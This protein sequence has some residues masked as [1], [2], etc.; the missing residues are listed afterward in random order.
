M[1]L[2]E[3]G[4]SLQTAVPATEPEAAAPAAAE[5]VYRAAADAF[6]GQAA[7]HM[8]SGP[9][10]RS[11]AQKGDL[12]VPAKAAETL[13]TQGSAAIQ[14]ETTQPE[15]ISTQPTLPTAVPMGETEGAAAPAELFYREGEPAA[16]FAADVQTAI[17]TQL[18]QRPAEGRHGKAEASRPGKPA[19]SANSPNNA[20][21][22]GATQ[23]QGAAKPTA[24]QSQDAMP[25]QNDTEAAEETALPAAIPATE[26]E[27]DTA[28]PA[29]LIYRTQTGASAL[30]GA[31]QA[32]DAI[33][34]SRPAARIARDIRVSAPPQSAAAWNG[35]HAASAPEPAGEIQT[36]ATA[37][38]APEET[39]MGIPPEMFY[40]APQFGTAPEAPSVDAV[41]PT[42]R[43]Q[44]KAGQSDM[45][46][47]AKD[48][49]EKAGVKDTVEYTSAFTGQAAASSGQKQ[50]TWTAPNVPDPRQ[51]SS[52]SGPM[53]LTFKEQTV[54][55]EEPF[56]KQM[57]SDAEIQRTADRVYHILEERLRR[58]LRRS[59]R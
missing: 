54:Q 16:E 20:A 2:E 42:E 46:A 50:I 36:S 53:D 29:E 37:V 49:L 44:R 56:Y 32:V 43:A 17:K 45:P 9:V 21:T 10:S 13:D 27:A 39:A 25:A 23:T 19:L 47:W 12:P 31:A 35:Q 11:S 6:T 26:A 3:A 41:R 40:A 51:N 59:G 5:I 18:A 58:E 52:I 48:L 1:T 4:P 57:V 55:E 24:A 30:Q 8:Q 7:S 34:P 22:H 14:G 33:P 28:S 38:P 15:G